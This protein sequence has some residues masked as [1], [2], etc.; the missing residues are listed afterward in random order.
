MRQD[1]GEVKRSFNFLDL[2][3]KG[4]EKESDYCKFTTSTTAEL[5][6]LSIRLREQYIGILATINMN[7][8]EQNQIWIIY[9]SYQRSRVANGVLH[10]SRALRDDV[11][12]FR[13]FLLEDI[14]WDK[15][16]IER[17]GFE[18]RNKYFH[19]ESSTIIHLKLL[20]RYDLLHR[21]GNDLF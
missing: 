15:E 11:L 3:E 10:D 5:G 16:Q 13:T 14:L 18:V 8:K 21:H 4:E 20:N 12:D 19:N 7:S 6:R 2:H 17:I 9:L 1:N